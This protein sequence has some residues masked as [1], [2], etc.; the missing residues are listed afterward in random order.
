[1]KFLLYVLISLIYLSPLSAMEKPPK[2]EADAMGMPA[3]IMIMDYINGG[4]IQDALLTHAMFLEENPK[5]AYEIFSSLAAQNSAEPWHANALLQKG[6]ALSSGNGVKKNN[7]QALLCYKECFEKHKD[8]KALAC[9]GRL[10]AEDKTDDNRYKKA[11]DCYKKAFAQGDPMAGSDL[12]RLI[13]NE[14]IPAPS[15]SEVADIIKFTQP[16]VKKGI[17]EACYLY[18][19]T[20]L[21]NNHEDFSTHGL[22]AL[23]EAAK[24]EDAFSAIQLAIL[25]KNGLYVPK[26]TK[27]AN[28]I[29]E[30]ALKMEDTDINKVAKAYMYKNGLGVEKN[31]AKAK[32]LLREGRKKLDVNQSYIDRLFSKDD[33]LDFIVEEKTPEIVPSPSSAPKP[34][35]MLRPSVIAPPVQLPTEPIEPPA[36]VIKASSIIFEPVVSKKI[37]ETV[38]TKVELPKVVML[39]QEIRIR[40]LLDG[41]NALSQRDDG[42][43]LELDFSRKKVLVHDPKY[44]HEFV[45]PFEE[46][47]F[48]S[49][50]NLAKLRYDERIAQWFIKSLK[51]LKSNDETRWK[52]DTHRFGKAVDYLIQ[53]I[54]IK[55]PIL[56]ARADQNSLMHAAES[57]TLN[58]KGH[59]EYTFRKEGTKSYLFHRHYRPYGK[60]P[61]K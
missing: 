6:L 23:L 43:Y 42:S 53:L 48:R 7:Q 19:S 21:D 49:Y 30:K 40:N 22:P 4:R 41:C 24:Q 33:T 17:K 18:A 55:N 12:A 1:M 51:D 61:K 11:A 32:Q 9:M 27:L 39:P 52:I 45:V 58:N 26:D 3:P 54:G 36:A 20:L 29:L 5:K 8:P 31:P 37:V 16:A 44:K 10:H 25:F 59:F 56:K 50:V 34:V 57:L 46:E 13:Y 38:K 47:E 35:E 60:E 15:G 28:N 2:N 14:D